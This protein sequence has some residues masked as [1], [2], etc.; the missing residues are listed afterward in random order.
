MRRFTTPTLPYSVPLNITA[1][2]IHVDIKQGPKKLRK[3]GTDIL[4]LAY[5]SETN[6]TTFSLRLSQE[7]T[8]SFTSG[9]DAV[10]QVNWIFEDGTRGATAERKISIYDNLLN[11]V[12]EYED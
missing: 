8:G 7:E 5:D 6:M 1:A 9:K 3:G 10:T 2:Q 12:I 4:N 11:E